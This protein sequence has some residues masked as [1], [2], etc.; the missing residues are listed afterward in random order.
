MDNFTEK[1]GNLV[2]LELVLIPSGSFTIGV[3][4]HSDPKL[5]T[6]LESGIDGVGMVTAEC[7]AFEVNIESFLIGRYPVTQEQWHYV[8]S[9]PKIR[10]KLDPDPSFFKGKK[11]P[12]EQITWDQA[13]E[14]CD[15]LSKLTGRDYRLPSETEWEYACR[16]G[17]DTHFYFGSTLTPNLANY[18]CEHNYSNYFQGKNYGGRY[19][20]ET[21]DVGTFPP[22]AYGL[23]DMHGNVK[24]WCADEWY[25]S[26]N[27]TPNNGAPAIWVKDVPD[28]QLSMN[29][30]VEYGRRRRI[31]RGGSWWSGSDS[32]RSG[33]RSYDGG[34]PNQYV[35]FRV[36]CD[37]PKDYSGMNLQQKNFSGLNLNRC[38]FQNANLSQAFFNNAQLIGADFT[39]A[40]L[41]GA[42]FENVQLTG[43]NFTDA[44]L[45]GANFSN[46][47]L[48]KAILNGADLSKA[49]LKGANLK[50]AFF[51]GVNLCSVCLSGAK[52]QRANFPK[53]DLSQVDFSNADLTEANFRGANLSRARFTHAILNRVDLRYTN[54][55]KA[56][57]SSTNTK[58]ISLRET[59]YKNTDRLGVNLT[60]ANLTGADLTGANLWDADLRWTNLEQVNL[61]GAIVELALFGSNLGLTES[62]KLDLL[63]R[64]ALIFD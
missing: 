64:G 52:L 27:K 48:S 22:N 18:N 13:N 1:L 57:F 14:F 46:A 42:Y 5:E 11:R 45:S 31:T 44:D 20:G 29:F 32:C 24:E 47:D 4:W 15:R 3:P 9:L 39:K 16:A 63:E 37:F 40:S 30:R 38:L 43:T 25:E 12:V 35:G 62:Q 33:Y 56:I 8:A 10:T 36:V 61:D 2:E 23:Y 53:S 21:T 17:T 28:Y 54:L 19:R 51:Y 34:T 7:P 49:I 26:Y 59:Y 60:T 41:K 55:K 50:N 6:T 58:K